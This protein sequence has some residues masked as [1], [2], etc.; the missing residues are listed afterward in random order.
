MR[1]SVLA[2]L[3]SS[4]ALVGAHPGGHSIVGRGIDINAFRLKA[5]SEYVNASVAQ[6]PSA[7]RRSRRGDYVGAA[8]DLVKSLVNDNAA[9]YRVVE[10]HYVGTNGIAHVNFKQTAN[11]LDI[12]NADTNVNVSATCF[13]PMTNTYFEQVNPDGT[14]FSHG[15]SFF[16]GNIPSNPLTKR[17]FS[18]PVDALKTATDML[19]H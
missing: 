10:D 8:T 18:D 1:G 11:G 19:S 14:I 9:S 16:F 5:T 4:L 2:G 6:T 12:D 17:D 15:S 3:A 13:S 7:V